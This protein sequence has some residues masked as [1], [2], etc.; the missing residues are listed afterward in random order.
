M[1]LLN[2]PAIRLLEQSLDASSLRQKVT[3]N[4]I[5][6]VDTP[7][8]KR[9]DVRFEELLQQELGALPLEGKRTDP[10]HFV[11]NTGSDSFPQV[12]LDDKS[13]MNNNLNNVDIDSEMA[14]MAKNQLRYNTMVQQMNQEIRHLRT[15]IE[16]RK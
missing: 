15:A 16:G 10:R 9:S 7:R 13:V 8:F 4:N 1:Y 12:V 2:T 5:A 11:F 14:L 3:A 6:N